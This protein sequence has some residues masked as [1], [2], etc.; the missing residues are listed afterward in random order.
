MHSYVLSNAADRD[1]QHII[2]HSITRWGAGRAESYILG[3]HKAFE[4][5]SAFPHLGRSAEH[6]RAGYFRFEH[7]SHTVFYRIAASGILIVRVLHQK[8]RPENYL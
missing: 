8:Q 6:I 2:R 1:L 4:T 3:L 5:L 7:D